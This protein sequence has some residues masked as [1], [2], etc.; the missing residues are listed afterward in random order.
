M[1]VFSIKFCNF[2]RVAKLGKIS[3]KK[4]HGSHESYSEIL[5]ILSQV[6]HMPDR[7][8]MLTF[9]MVETYE[10]TPPP[11]R[12]FALSVISGNRMKLSIIKD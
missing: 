1:I 12:N 10:Q 4:H 9:L 8:T 11:Y 2:S 3:G 6:F 5:F 7:K